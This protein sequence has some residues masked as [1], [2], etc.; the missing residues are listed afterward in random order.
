MNDY[1][2][3]NFI[4]QLR[5]QKGITQDDLGRII[6]V[7]NKAISKWEN[8][9]AKPRLEIIKKLAD[10][11]DV[12]VDELLHGER[13]AEPTVP[14]QPPIAKEAASR[15][16]RFFRRAWIVGAGI[17]ALAAVTV[18]LVFLILSIRR[19]PGASP[20]EPTSPG[21][22][23]ETEACAHE[24]VGT[25][26]YATCTEGGYT[27]HTC[28]LCG[29]SYRDSEVA[30][31]NHDWST[32]LKDDGCVEGMVLH[33]TC[34]RC[35]AEALE[36]TDEAGTHQYILKSRIL[37]T[38]TTGGYDLYACKYCQREEQRNPTSP[39]SYS[40]GLTYTKMNGQYYASDMGSCM[41]TDLVIPAVNEYG[42]T[43]VGIADGWKSPSVKNVQSILIEEGIRDIYSLDAFTNARTISLPLSAPQT[44]VGVF[45]SDGKVKEITLYLTDSALDYYGTGPSYLS[46]ET[47]HL[48]GPFHPSATLKNLNNVSVVTVPDSWSSLPAEFCYGLK[49]LTSFSFPK[50]LKSISA[51]CFK[52][53]GLTEAVLP[54]GVTLI[55]QSAFETCPLTSVTLPGSLITVGN[56]A[57]QNTQLQ[58]ALVLPG[59]L[60]K[61]G[62]YS[63]S[64][65]LITSVVIPNS[66]TEA[67]Y[68]FKDCKLLR[69]VT[70]GSGV[71]SFHDLFSGCTALESVTLSDNLVKLDA[72][73]FSGCTSLSEISLPASVRVIGQSAFSGCSSLSEIT[74]PDQLTQIGSKA[75]YQC[76]LLKNITVP[77][78]VSVFGSEIFSGC[79]FLRSCTF[80]C[81]MTEIPQAM[82]QNCRNLTDIQYPDA[83]NITAIRDGAF[84]GCEKLSDFPYE[85]V[86]IIGS[87][88]FCYTALVE[89]VV[90]EGVTELNFVFSG[91][92]KL[93]S[94]TLPD[95]L[96]TMNY[97]LNGCSSLTELTLP[98][99]LTSFNTANFTGCTGLTKLIVC[100]EK[101]LFTGS[102]AS[103]PFPVLSELIVKE[104]ASVPVLD[105]EVVKSITHVE[106]PS[107]LR[108]I[109]EG[110]F[111][112]AS[113]L[114]SI[115]LPKGLTEIGKNAFANAGLESITLPEG[116][117]KIGENAFANTGLD[118]VTI[119]SSVT[120][121]G[122][123]AFYHCLS[124]T[125]VDL[126]GAATS[127]GGSV[128][129]GDTQLS[130][131]Q[132]AGNI[133]TLSKTDLQDTP[134][135][136]EKNGLVVIGK[137]LL[138]A[139]R[140]TVPVDLTIPDEVQVITASAISGCTTLRSVTF[141]SGVTDIEAS[142]F[143]DCSGLL[144]IDW[145][146]CT[147]R[148]I[149]TD[150]F[151][152]CGI[153]ELVLP[154]GVEA[155]G[156]DVFYGCTDL[157][158][159]TVPDSYTEIPDGF[160]RGCTSLTA[161]VIG[162][163]LK[164]VGVNAFA[165][166]LRAGDPYNRV[167]TLSEITYA[168][169]LEEFQTIQWDSS[170]MFR[171][172]RVTVTASDGISL[173]VLRSESDANA[174]TVLTV[175][176]TLTLSGV[177]QAPA[178]NLFIGSYGAKVLK[179]VFCEGITG[180]E[181]NFNLCANVK[182]VIFSS[183]VTAFPAFSL[184]NT[185][186][187]Q[188][189]DPENGICINGNTLLFC[190]NDTVGTVT[191][192][193][194]ITEIGSYAFYNCLKITEIIFPSTLK[195]IGAYAFNGTNL[196]HLV[197]PDQ[198]ILL[199]ARLCSSGVS[200]IHI[201]LT[202][203]GANGVQ[204]AVYTTQLE[205]VVFREGTVTIPSY[206]IWDCTG[207]I[208]AV[209]PDSVT[210]IQWDSFNR[211]VILCFQSE[212]TMQALPSGHSFQTA[213]YCEEPPTTNGWFW[214]W[215]ADGNPVLWD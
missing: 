79:S 171:F 120:S 36:H 145:N 13:K 148:S 213:L 206:C 46:I 84:S 14:E 214:H 165:V 134:L 55:E 110:A 133:T 170:N 183:T 88:A 132:N 64:N 20:V 149:G 101:A 2:F 129:A 38:R 33:S 212:S 51:S 177:G 180:Y 131:F 52:G 60:K 108:S 144:R 117:I 174:S 146:G 98:K 176:G 167:C 75:F 12:S 95:S 21:N 104:G 4:Y 96:V 136:E 29:D 126:S 156:S 65:T 89:V 26:R 76:V 211:D 208:L 59:R 66:V 181:D 175:D 103:G 106:L 69:S 31:L 139:N 186:W 179:I 81:E 40:V 130:A 140:L 100:S 80:L 196:Y 70:V 193:E 28:R 72:N 109:P 10:Y 114:T 182:E 24:Y 41:D 185:P 54:D 86:Q 32:V 99:N 158:K 128:F 210:S 23:T 3:G 42:Q 157:C 82:F 44:S 78:T 162:K 116:L 169:T 107:T 147:P 19:S 200:P 184:V 152:Q 161:A 153:L 205:T 91:C 34:S 207:E 49:K 57:F 118:S 50:Q 90:P 187:Y 202:A 71:S 199:E 16:P 151:R 115:T 93:T 63:F 154:E 150:A 53:S 87:N 77:Q 35:G 73:L 127:L 192:P 201:T 8:G 137:F 68:A 119:P 43:V 83:G 92:R 9:A 105:S 125:C 124:L 172:Q 48:I 56:W 25:V 62:V 6:G 164:Q 47:V 204:V 209:I 159:I 215:D 97:C 142:A 135:M 194:G 160:F 173:E 203:T 168:G 191:V 74:L 30:P 122:Q 67:T 22:R 102:A 5:T 163:N 141:H 1:K 198:E 113:M 58:G 27:T 61:M 11:F 7:S 143:L 37:P 39:V 45:P 195:R 190:K 17:C 94:I 166:G 138:D 189:L 188:E 85:N 178:I 197:L 111:S 155:W 112:G 15:F 123:Y 121:I 18:G